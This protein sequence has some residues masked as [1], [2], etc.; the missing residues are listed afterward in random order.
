MFGPNSKRRTF[1][2]TNLVVQWLAQ[3]PFT[4]ATRVRFLLGAV[5]RLKNSTLVAC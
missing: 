1:H 3:V 4:S 2:E 5:I